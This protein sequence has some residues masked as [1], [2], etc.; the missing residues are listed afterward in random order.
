MKG[1]L[2]GVAGYIGNVP[3]ILRFRNFRIV[4]F[5][6]DHTPAHIHAIGPDV[7]AIFTLNCWRGPVVRR[8]SDQTKLADER[9]LLQFVSDN[10]EVLCK[11]WETIHG[12]PTRT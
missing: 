4:I 8:S 6:N 11:A 3:A 7:A 12:D 10:L 5:P 9:A 2:I 1:L